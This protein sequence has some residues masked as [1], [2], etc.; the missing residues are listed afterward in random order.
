MQGVFMYNV[1]QSGLDWITLLTPRSAACKV[2]GAMPL[3][4][5]YLIWVCFQHI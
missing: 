2:M 1:K 4:I 3:T 5:R